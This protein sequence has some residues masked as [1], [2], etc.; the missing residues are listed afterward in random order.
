ML[1]PY[2]KK[3]EDIRNRKNADGEDTTIYD[4]VLSLY[5]LINGN[6]DSSNIVDNSLISNS[7]N[8]NWKSYTTTTTPDTG[9]TYTS[10][11]K[12]ARYT[13]IGKIILL[14]IYVTGT[15][16]GTAGNTMK[17][18]LPVKSS[19]NFTS[20]SMSAR[21]NDGTATGGTAWISPVTTTTD[22]FVRKR[23]ASN[24]TAGTVS[25]IVTGFYEVD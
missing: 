5:D 25:F 12:N 8:I 19:S 14:N 23:D 4:A 7:F 1:M 17:L 11:T 10:L 20:C 13:K 6:L 24:F 16:G 3:L 9:M 22:V 18:S 21:V 15:I 2:D